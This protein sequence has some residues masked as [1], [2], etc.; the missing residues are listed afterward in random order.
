MPKSE[1][2]S[3]VQAIG[4]VLAIILAV[5]VVQKQ[6][7]LELHRQ[8]IIEL[9]RVLANR[10]GA[11]QLISGVLSVA[12]K[13]KTYCDLAV[14]AHAHHPEQLTI[15]L[16]SLADAMD[17]LETTMNAVAGADHLL[18]DEHAVIEALMVAESTGRV[19]Y[20][21]GKL[22]LELMHQDQQPHWTD[23][24]M[25]AQRVIVALKPRGDKIHADNK[26]LF[27][28]ISA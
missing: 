7:T 20:R 14:G 3:W 17:E 22:A 6:H 24:S 12:Q 8:D 4:S 23:I 15:G 25:V 9:R 26:V 16:N 10:N 27:D 19:L 11:L 5:W 1:W 2:A 28:A 13:I 18:F 21:S